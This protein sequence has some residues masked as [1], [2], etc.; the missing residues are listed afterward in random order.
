MTKIEVS[1]SDYKA[2]VL[3]FSGTSGWKRSNGKG[4]FTLEEDN[5]YPRR[6]LKYGGIVF[7]ETIDSKN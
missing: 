1:P 2:L 7:V 3:Q 6:N 4:S 5:K